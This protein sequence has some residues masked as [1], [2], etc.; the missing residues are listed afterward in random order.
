MSE[1][2]PPRDPSFFAEIRNLRSRSAL[3]PLAYPQTLSGAGVGL[4]TTSWTICRRWRLC[5]RRL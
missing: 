5:R 3:R 2:A 4:G 1:S